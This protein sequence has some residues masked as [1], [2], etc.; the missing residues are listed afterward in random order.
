M[1][2]PKRLTILLSTQKKLF[3]RS[4]NQCAFPSCSKSLVDNNDR[5]KGQICHIEAAMPGGER[6][7]G[8]MS[9]EERRSYDNLILLCFDH[10]DET[11]DTAN[12][13]VR[14][15]KEMK[16]NHELKVKNS[17]GLMDKISNFYDIDTYNTQSTELLESKLEKALQLLEKKET[18]G[19]LGKIDY[20]KPRDYIKRN[21]F[22]AR[23]YE[24]PFDQRHYDLIEL[25]KNKNRI[26]LLGVA[27]SGKSIELQNLA[28]HYSSVSDDL[29]PIKIRLNH[30]SRDYDIKKLLSLE[31]NGYNDIKDQALLIILDGLDEVHSDDLGH[32]VNN[33]SNYGRE[34]PDSVIVVSCRNNFYTIESDKIDSKIEGFDTFVLNPL[35]QFNIQRHVELILQSN[36]KKFLQLIYEKKLFD[37]LKSPFYLVRLL[38]YFIKEQ[39]VP[40]TKKEIFE[41]LINERLAEDKM[42]KYPN[43]GVLIGDYQKKI[44]D[45][46][47][48]LA[49]AAQA[50]GRNYLTDEEYEELNPDPNLRKLIKYTSFLDQNKYYNWEFEHN[51][52]QEYL[53]AKYLSNLSVDW[54]KKFVSFDPHFEKVKPTWVNT[55]SLLLSI[56]DSKSGKFNDLLNWIIHIEPDVLV[57]FEKDKID[58]TNR[59]NIFRAIYGKYEKEKIIIRSEKY[60]S[61]ELAEFVADSGEI[62]KLLIQKAHSLREYWKVS[63]AVRLFKYFD[64]WEVYKQQISDMLLFYISDP[65]VPDGTKLECFHA[66]SS[67]KIYSEGITQKILNSI[68]LESSKNLRAGFYS[69]LANANNIDK[70]NSILSKSLE[71]IKRPNLLSGSKE[72]KGEIYPSEE[73]YNLQHL[74]EKF[75]SLK[76]TKSLIEWGI[77]IE[78]IRRDVTH[79]DILRIAIKNAKHLSLHHSEDLY[80]EVFELLISIVK[81]YSR[82]LD[83]DFN[84]YFKETQNSLKAFKKLRKISNNLNSNSPHEYYHAIIVVSD[85]S[86]V[87]NILEEYENGKLTNQQV[88]T[89]RD[90]FG[91]Y[92][93]LHDLFYKR[94]NKLSNNRFVYIKIDHEALRIKKLHNDVS[95]I[96][97]RN[98]FVEKMLE[99]F[100]FGETDQFTYEEIWDFRKKY[101]NDLE[102][103]NNIVLQ[104]LRQ[105]SKESQVIKR[106]DVK[107]LFKSDLN[108]YWFQI[109]KI[110]NIDTQN[111]EFQFQI[112][113]I[114]HLKNWLSD[115]LIK[116][117]FQTAVY[118]D[119]N[120]K[121]SYRYLE[122]YIPYIS[123]RLRI[124]LEASIY[125]DF[126]FLIP[127]CIPSK[128]F[129]DKNGDEITP[130]NVNSYVV[131]MVG[132]DKAKRR[133]VENIKH[134]SLVG[135][136]VKYNHCKFCYDYQL[137]EGLDL[138]LQLIR[139][140]GY[141]YE[142]RQLIVWYIKLGGNP[143]SIEILLNE[144]DENLCFYALEKLLENGSV[145]S[146]EYCIDKY[147]LVQDFE[148]KFQYLHLVFKYYPNKGLK[149]YKDWVISNKIIP[150]IFLKPKELND[151]KLNDFIDLF[152]DSLNNNYDTDEWHNRNNIIYG[153]VEL[154]SRNEKNFELAKAKF[155]AW[156][157]NYPNTKYL[158]Y[159]IQKLELEYYS[160][161]SQSLTLD[162][163][164]SLLHES[165]INSD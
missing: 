160:K 109:G 18:F 44:K 137:P 98:H 58:L 130:R 77:G 90:I 92:G 133:I 91:N 29:F 13:S 82:E 125:L 116:A 43:I 70:Y 119:E 164:N 47:Q 113:A 20:Q 108:W 59:E 1:E 153:I 14:M 144:F 107:N 11:N 50:F 95:I 138:I 34:F 147:K 157:K 159:Q 69:Y 114:N 117:D 120:E 161:F 65:A 139:I 165:K 62:L 88:Y 7:N 24:N 80:A 110:L 56:L 79:F 57:R 38:E 126:L 48:I 81:S 97:D 35:N 94:I 105:T 112:S 83:K 152:E 84:E 30:Y 122:H 31:Y 60:N 64:S 73:S 49:I 140:T 2:E 146:L 135:F 128:A 145:Y 41:F 22:S 9:N 124:D 86:C 106:A 121:V 158:L 40:D 12:Y 72:Q 123:H 101:L 54:I 71:F 151:D 28:N 78:E 149:I 67:L 37:L 154:G 131:S 53:A 46:I 15:L 142:K 100:D 51:N 42:K 118:L 27:G 32:A 3:L 104:T 103:D 75:S 19:N 5:L 132:V 93:D 134:D 129:E 136:R 85:V 26:T 45:K 8:N 150:N 36:S 141:D 52:F 143:N 25:V 66:L 61:T 111:K 23:T 96:L 163:L 33:I 127:T 148:L 68:D 21:V 17:S 102:A 76:I 16:R 39:S 87:N 89:F 74:F 156:V 4:G 115:A 162:E 6:F 63:E 10:H 55:L 99:I 155:E